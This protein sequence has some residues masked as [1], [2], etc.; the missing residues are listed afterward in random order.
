MKSFLK[1][2]LFFSYYCFPWIKNDFK[3]VCLQPGFLLEVHSLQVSNSLWAS[4]QRSTSSSAVCST[5]TSIPAQLG[6]G[7]PCLGLA[8]LCSCA[9]CIYAVCSYILIKNFKMS[10]MCL[11]QGSAP[12]HPKHSS[13]L[14]SIHLPICPS[15]SKPAHAELSTMSF[16]VDD[17]GSDHITKA[18]MDHPL[19][20]SRHGDAVMSHG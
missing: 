13:S 5:Q 1:P 18:N 2:G 7:A 17:T 20:V 15:A 8:W 12:P 19:P 14:Q 11:S 6:Y 10:S 3:K 16:Y 9:S 4:S